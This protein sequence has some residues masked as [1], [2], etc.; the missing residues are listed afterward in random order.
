MKTA[1][2]AHTKKWDPLGNIFQGTWPANH[3]LRD[4]FTVRLLHD[5]DD[6]RMSWPLMQQLR[7]N[8][9]DEGGYLQQV[10]RLQQITGYNLVG[11]FDSNGQLLGL[12]GFVCSEM[13]S[14][15]SYLY[16]DDLVIDEGHRSQ[17]I[18]RILI[19]WLRAHARNLGCSSLHLDCSNHRLDSH[20]FYR[21]EGLEDRS[22]HFVLDI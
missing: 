5:L 12:A 13:L 22:L 18:G 6:I 16:V 21:R 3:M 2:T 19:S 9:S 14:R 8:Q 1:N 4:G 15:G 7:P 17:G 10:E 20:R 11:A